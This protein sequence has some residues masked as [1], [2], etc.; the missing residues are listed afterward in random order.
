MVALFPTFSRLAQRVKQV[1][2]ADVDSLW[3]Q[4][5]QATESDESDPTVYAI[6]THLHW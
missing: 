6:G 2:C 1:L 4:L 5:L 3:Q